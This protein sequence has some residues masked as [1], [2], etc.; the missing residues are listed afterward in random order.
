M[1]NVHELLGVYLWLIIREREREREGKPSHEREKEILSV[2]ELFLS[3]NCLSV[4]L[5]I[6]SLEFY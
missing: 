6:V 3:K 2:N 4:V 5:F 1:L